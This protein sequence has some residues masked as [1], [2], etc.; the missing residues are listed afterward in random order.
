M[1]KQAEMHPAYAWDCDDCGAENFNR[2][3]VPEM[4]D[5]DLKELRDDHGVQ[6]WEAGQF[7]MMP[8]EVTCAKCGATFATAHMLDDDT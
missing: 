2:A 6:P 8:T 7:M 5:D 1:S 3:I 4:S